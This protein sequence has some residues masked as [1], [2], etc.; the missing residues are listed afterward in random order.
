[1]QC[2][3]Y[4]H[5]VGRFLNN[6]LDTDCVQILHSSFSHT[7]TPSASGHTLPVQLGSLAMALLRTSMAAAAEAGKSLEVCV[8]ACMRTSRSAIVVGQI[9]YNTL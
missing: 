3:L 9:T 4:L 8:L 2:T 1:M 7:P 6:A 5:T